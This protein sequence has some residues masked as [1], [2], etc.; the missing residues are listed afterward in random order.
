MG[1]AAMSSDGATTLR[2]PASPT[3]G[4]DRSAP[5]APRF[6]LALGAKKTGNTVAVPSRKRPRA[7]LGEEA[8]EEEGNVHQEISTF[9]KGAETVKKTERIIQSIPNADWQ[10][11]SR[12]K[13]QKSALPGNEQARNRAGEVVPDKIN[14]EEPKF[15]LNVIERSEGHGTGQAEVT[16]PA[17]DNV[18]TVKTKTA[19]EEA[20]EA[21]TNGK[22]TAP[23]TITPPS[24]DDAFRDSYDEAPDAPSAQDFA[25]TPV[26]GFGA[27]ILRGYLT[28]GRTLEDLGYNEDGQDT[29]PKRRAG[30]LGL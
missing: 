8:V 18:P 19:D 20:L 26:E 30:L 13:K 17:D 14:V 6:S 16:P 7:A 23:K 15:G 1:S 21:L 2:A 29:G 24:E 10:D 25:A 22:H 27:A 11:P 28:G 12:R 4:Y 5:V 9:G 3:S